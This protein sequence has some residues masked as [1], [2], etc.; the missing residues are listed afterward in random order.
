MPGSALLIYHLI[1]ARMH[2]GTMGFG[3]S[4]W[5]RV[6]YPAGMKAGEY[7][8]RYAKQFDAVEL[9]TTFHATPPVDRVRKWAEMV[10]ERF[11]VCP[12]APKA[13]THEGGLARGA[14]EMQRFLDTMRELGEKLG[15]VLIQLPPSCG[16]DQFEALERLLKTLPGDLRFAVEFRNSSWGI[17]RTL[18][19]LK[20]VGCGLV[21]AEYLSRP[22]RIHLT[23]DF[24]YLRLIGEHERFEKLNQVQADVSGS[25]EF[26]RE[27]IETVKGQIEDGWVFFSNDFSGYAIETCR[28]FMRLMGEP[29]R[30]VR[31]EGMLFG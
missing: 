13:V 26:W 20:G 9:D 25:L 10:P 3:Y 16:V 30:E 17:P 22:T 23:A 29:V 5:A 8:S 19:M 11:R 4:D 24:T 2:Y 18:E 6:F 14:G 28:E 27:Q 31:D 12:K 21:A 1:M 15:V 7:L